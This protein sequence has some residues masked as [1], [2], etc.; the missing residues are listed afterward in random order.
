[1][2]D[3]MSWV[4]ESGEGGAGGGGGGGWVGGG[5]GGRGGEIFGGLVLGEWGGHATA[6]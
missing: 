4:C 5:G 2:V 6:R 3:C 1:M